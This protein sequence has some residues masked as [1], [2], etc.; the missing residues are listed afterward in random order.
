MGGK[1]VPQLLPPWYGW[2][3]LIT[4]INTLIFIALRVMYVPISGRGLAGVQ[5]AGRWM[6]VPLVLQ[7]L[8]VVLVFTNVQVCVRIGCGDFLL[9]VAMAFPE[10]RR[11]ER[12]GLISCPVWGLFFF[13]LNSCG[14]APTSWTRCFASLAPSACVCTSSFSR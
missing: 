10:T 1:V 13:H 12:S 7:A 11:W 8:S 6:I 4:Y 2:G 14:Y 9:M 3:L 5:A